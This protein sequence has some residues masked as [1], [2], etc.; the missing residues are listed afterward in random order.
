MAEYVRSVV[1]ML[2]L[3]LQVMSSLLAMSVPSL[4]VGLV[5]SMSG[6]MGTSPVL[7]ARLDIGGTKVSLPEFTVNLAFYF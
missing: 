4:F 5:M 1:I 6:K 2:V 7:S 3:Q